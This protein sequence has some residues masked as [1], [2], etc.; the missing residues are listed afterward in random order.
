VY[1]GTGNPNDDGYLQS[2]Q[3]QPTIQ[4]QLDERAFRDMYAL[5]AANPF[6]LGLPRTIRLG[7]KFDF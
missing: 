2:A 7:I 3:F 4:N 5:N 1:R 6:N